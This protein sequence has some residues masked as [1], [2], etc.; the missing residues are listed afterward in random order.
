V[1]A[2]LGCSSMLVSAVLAAAASTGTAAAAAAAAAAAVY[3][4]GE[5][6]TPCRWCGPPGCPCAAPRWTPTYDMARSTI[7]QPCNESGLLDPEL[8]SRFGVVSLVRKYASQPRPCV[9]QPSAS[10]PLAGW[11]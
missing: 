11:H 8:M 7:I 1:A 10:A 2:S 9:S 5:T 3:D 4:A 6:P